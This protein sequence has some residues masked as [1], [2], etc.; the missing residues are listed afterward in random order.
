MRRIFSIPG[1]AVL[2]LLLTVPAL[3][4]PD[5]L[6]GLW[7]GTLQSP[8]GERPTKAIFKKEG[9]AYTGKMLG[10]R[11]N[12]VLLKDVKLDG[13]KLTA[14]AEIDTG[15]GQITINYTLTLEG[16]SL[17]GQGVLDIAGQSIDIDVSLKRVSTQAPAS[18][19]APSP[20]AAPGQQAPQSQP[21]PAQGQGQPAQQGQQGQQRQRQPEVPQP[22]QKQS[23]D[24]FAGQWQ[25]EYI[26]RESAFG[27][28]PR[29]CVLNFTK[30][31]DGKSVEG[32]A[33]CK[34]DAGAHQESWVLVFDEASKTLTSTEKRPGSIN[35]LSR[36]DWTSPISIRFAVEPVKA[37][38]QTLQ[39]RRIISVVAPHSFT[40]TEEL[41]EDG[42]PFVRLGSAVVSKVGA[43]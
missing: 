28:A 29:Q 9:D 35:L 21:A 31:P 7:E 12:E 1:I 14:K 4:Q 38:G 42:G 36:A 26:G 33:N 40:I 25:Y 20:Q 34:T 37:K 24:Y 17:K 43:K 30:R 19:D 23:I 27:A 39:L 32:V 6:V 5:K 41:S 8:Q 2:A 15:Q 11:G 16:E 3:A 18:F 10:M 22:Q 13:N